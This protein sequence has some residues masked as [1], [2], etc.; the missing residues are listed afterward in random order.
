[1]K[2]WLL[3]FLIWILFFPIFGSDTIYINPRDLFYKLKEGFYI[4]LRDTGEERIIKMVG[5]GSK[6]EYAEKVVMPFLERFI[7]ASRFEADPKE[8][9]EFIGDK[10]VH[11]FAE[12][13]KK[14]GTEKKSLTEYK[15]FLVEGLKTRK[16]HCGYEANIPLNSIYGGKREQLLSD[17]GYF[18]IWI[19]FEAKNTNDFNFSS[20]D[21]RNYDLEKLRKGIDFNVIKMSGKSDIDNGRFYFEYNIQKKK[22]ELSVGYD[23]FGL[24]R[25]YDGYMKELY[26]PPKKPK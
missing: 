15:E 24:N 17:D 13:C 12:I 26:S 19:Y 21:E 23:Q 8:I 4:D 10:Y 5:H 16:M 3:T 22:H 7:Y 20:G 25:L 11:Q 6:K 14:Q 18:L 1:M 9:Y 2:K